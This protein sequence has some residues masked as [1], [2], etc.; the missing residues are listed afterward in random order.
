M[1]Y[2]VDPQ[3]KKESLYEFAY[4]SQNHIQLLAD[5]ALD[6]VWY[7]G[8]QATSTDQY[9]ILRSYLR[10]TYW[11]LYKE[12]KICFAQDTQAP[13]NNVSV[14][15]YA[16]FNTGLVDKKYEYIYALFGSNV[17]YDQPWYSIGFFVAGQDFGGKTLVNFF[18]PL[19]PKANYFEGNMQNLF[20]DTSSGDIIL[21]YEHII[22]E[23]TERLPEKF[24]KKWI[25]DIDTNINDM[26]LDDAFALKASEDEQD[27]DKREE[28]FKEL[29]A[30][31]KNDSSVLNDMKERIE[32][33]KNIAMK[34]V[35][36]NYKT[37][38]PMYYPRPNKISLLL[39]LALVDKSK[40]D[41]ALVIERTL[42]GAYMGH[43]I[44]TLQMAYSNSRLIARPDSDWLQ[45]SVIKEPIEEFD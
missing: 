1:S 15:E 25:G 29:G 32:S 41:L 39:P 7:Y 42:S 5:L 35:E 26:S 3:K 10:W 9:R 44:L 2:T 17:G 30:R 13:Q 16:A 28:Y 36:W 8:D 31:I 12:D 27:K 34:R 37:A 45:T 4:I 14:K 6:E 18:N 21:D 33:A 19:P 24:V 40:V 20:L 22:C 38:V 43:T 11:R 23:H